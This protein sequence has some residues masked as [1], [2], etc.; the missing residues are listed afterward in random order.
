[1]ID[2]LHLR[3]IKNIKSRGITQSNRVRGVN[4]GLFQKMGSNHTY[5][6]DSIILYMPAEGMKFNYTA[7]YEALETG[8]AGDMAQGIAGVIA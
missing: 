6:S 1:M 5:I 2:Q 3:N 7:D 4:S 8:L